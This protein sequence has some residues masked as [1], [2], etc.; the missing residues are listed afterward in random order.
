M[1]NQEVHAIMENELRCVQ[2]ASTNCCDRDCAKCPLVMDTDKII[3]AYG[4]V[5]RMLEDNNYVVF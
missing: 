5:I 3:K 4:I 1:D 2:T